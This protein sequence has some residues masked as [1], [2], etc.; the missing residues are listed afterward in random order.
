M[1]MA[2]GQQSLSQKR[3]FNTS[4]CGLVFALGKFVNAKSYSATD[5]EPIVQLGSILFRRKQSHAERFGDC[6][7]SVLH[8]E[9]FI[10]MC[11]VCADGG[12]TY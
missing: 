6:R 2:F 7:R 8:I 4:A 9:F 12:T 1:N 3:N 10:D 5:F 11:N